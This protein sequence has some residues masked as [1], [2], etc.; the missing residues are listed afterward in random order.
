M[1]APED[2]ARDYNMIEWNYA[3]GVPSIDLKQFS[4]GTQAD[5][6]HTMAS[7]LRWLLGFFSTRFPSEN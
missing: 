1:Y 5:V 2:R 3:Q 4:I 6:L 7:K